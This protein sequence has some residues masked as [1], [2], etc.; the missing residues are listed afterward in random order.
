LTKKGLTASGQILVEIL[1]ALALVAIFMMVAVEG[2]VAYRASFSQSAQLFEAETLFLEQYETLKSVRERDWDNLLIGGPYH[3]AQSG[4]S[5]A[6]FPGPEQVGSFVRFLNITQVE[7]DQKGD[8]V[9]SGG[10]LDPN[11]KRITVNVAKIAPTSMPTGGP[12]PT[13]TSSPTSTPPLSPTP[14]PGPG[15]PP[16][17]F[18]DSTGK[19]RGYGDVEGGTDTNG[20]GVRDTGNG[21]VN[22]TGD[23]MTVAQIAAGLLTPTADQRRAADVNGDGVV[24]QDGDVALISQYANGQISTFPVCVCLISTP[25]PT[26]SPTPTS[27]LTP[28]V[29]P[30]LISQGFYLTRFVG[31]TFWLQ[32]TKSDFDQGFKDKVETTQPQQ[33]E[34]VLSKTAGNRQTLGNQFIATANL[35]TLINNSNIYLALRF[36]AQSSKTT[37]EVRFYQN[38]EFHFGQANYSVTLRADN[39]GNPGTV[40]AS[41]TYSP[42]QST[43]ARWVTVPLNTS[44]KLNPDSIYH[45]VIRCQSTSSFLSLKSTSPLNRLIPYDN[46]ADPNSNFLISTDAG[47]IWTATGQQPIYLLVFTDSTVEGNPL[48]LAYDDNASLTRIYGQ[49]VIGEEFTIQTTDQEVEN[50]GFYVRSLGTGGLAPEAD[51]LISLFNVTDNVPIITNG[52]LVDAK[53][54]TTTYG[55]YDFNLPPKTTLVAGKTY[56]LFLSSIGTTTNRAYLLTAQE[57]DSTTGNPGATFDG[58]QSFYTRSNNGGTIWTGSANRDVPFH[59]VVR[60]GKYETSGTFESQTFDSTLGTTGSSGFNYLTW[61]ASEPTGTNLNFQIATNTNGTTW[62]F[63]GP[64]G[65]PIT[66]FDLPQAIPLAN[67]EGKYFR[68]KAYFYSDS[69]G[70]NT[71]VLADVTLNYS[72]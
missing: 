68:F 55:W 18:I 2:F 45:L 4:N 64:D 9:E 34:V 59:Y 24:N 61:T 56:R 46:K 26:L 67:A 41:G 22:F 54:V 38:G 33:S 19:W 66:Y 16:C 52:K 31:N 48:N 62:N 30:Y 10:I 5:W 49:N 12:T 36:T 53:K 27:V 29:G 70:K 69:Q 35:A 25:S 65:S 6:L 23:V 71:P 17:F 14:T 7:R 51:L 21:V 43:P 37:R 72:P 8:V 57:T 11:T 42:F 63:V 28:P 20:D 3:I 39:N 1:L 50:V 32:T 47:N 40:L 58:T 15:S 60:L 44:V 13:P